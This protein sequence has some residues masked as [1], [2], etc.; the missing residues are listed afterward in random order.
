MRITSKGQV[1]IPQD[2]RERAGLLPGAEI[3]F[4][5]DGRVVRLYKARA[6]KKAGRGAALTARMRG[7]GD[8]KMT[9]DEIMALTRSG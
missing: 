6:P 8:V 9:T 5:Y 4:E 1:T 2:I 7:R 3:E